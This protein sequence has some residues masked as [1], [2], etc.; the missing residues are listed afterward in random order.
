MEEFKSYVAMGLLWNPGAN[1]TEL[2]QEFLNAHYGL[3]AAAAVRI[4]MQ[5]M[6]NATAATGYYMHES[7][8]ETAAFLTPT[9]ILASA[10]ALLGA[11]N[12]S[13]PSS[14]VAMRLRRLT[15]SIYYVALLRWD[16]LVT[17]AAAHSM[18]WPLESSVGAAFNAFSVAVNET[19]ARYGGRAVVFS[20]SGR[21]MA[22]FKQR[23]LLAC[24]DGS[25][26]TP[27]VPSAVHASSA[28][29]GPSLDGSWNAGGP[30]PAWI[31]FSFVQ[32]PPINTVVAVVDQAPAGLTEH[33][34]DIN[35]AT[36]VTWNGSTAAGD[37]LRWQ[38]ATATKVHTVRITTL[39]SPS[40]V[41][42]AGIAFGSCP[43]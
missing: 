3:E 6:L 17:Y 13:D 42:W 11:R 35:A 36:V 25:F 28:S 9:S 43:S 21:D 5:T 7:F 41:A 37:V 23:V 34:V 31:E 30:P 1:G 10:Q 27:V 22:W 24:A 40:W 8:D 15:L 39:V 38:A 32:A 18:A 33:V 2:E 26:T 12:A 14:A 29:S 20:E 19:E 16:E 4:Y